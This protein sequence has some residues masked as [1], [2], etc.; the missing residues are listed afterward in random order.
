MIK[1]Y[2]TIS[3]LVVSLAFIFFA[4][5]TVVNIASASTAK[6]TTTEQTANEATTTEGSTE[7]TPKEA[8][9]AE[10][11]EHSEDTGIVG[12]FGLNWKLF[13]AQLVNFGI[14]I[15]VLWKWVFGPVTKGLSDRTEKIEAS[16]KEADQV[17]KDRQDFE[18]WKQSEI[19]KVRA[20]AS[21]IITEAKQNAEALKAE[22]LKA[23]SEEQTK[24]VEQTKARLEQEKVSMIQ[25]AKSELA[26]I[27]VSATST[28]L[29]QK[30]DA[31]KDKE[32]IS[33][34]LKK[35]EQGGKA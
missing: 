33:E 1:R 19:N 35:A 18:S 31:T 15:F 21:G 4:N 13:L 8:T 28:I 26:E 20:E 9:T 29:K 27:V 2:F 16:L 11:E 32:L 25:S 5:F 24:L 3:T 6:P 17:T 22:T 23:T 30:I 7:S 10:S 34:A 12:M 14:I